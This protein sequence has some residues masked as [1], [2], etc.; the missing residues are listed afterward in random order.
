V[1]PADGVH[2]ELHSAPIAFA[3][4]PALTLT[5]DPRR[6]VTGD[7]TTISVTAE[8]ITT[9]RGRI[10]VQRRTRK[11]H[12]L[13]TKQRVTLVDGAAATSFTPT[14]AGTYRVTFQ[15]GGATVR[16]LLRAL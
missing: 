4:R 8:P 13:V 16:R 5:L 10:V 7:P 1:H 6:V 11:G 3:I 14:P 12:R 15:S 9:T 2:E